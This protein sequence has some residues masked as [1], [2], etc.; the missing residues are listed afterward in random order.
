VTISREV[1]VISVGSFQ[2]CKQL[3]AVAFEFASHVHCIE[4]RAFYQCS[5][6]RFVSL[7]PSTQ[8]LRHYC[9]AKC[10][11]LRELRFEDGLSRL[12]IEAQVFRDCR[13]L[14]RIALPMS[15]RRDFGG[16][17]RGLRPAI[18]C[19]YDGKCVSDPFARSLVHVTHSNHSLLLNRSCRRFGCH[20]ILRV[21]DSQT[22]GNETRFVIWACRVDVVR[23]RPV[24]VRKYKL[25]WCVWF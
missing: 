4:A 17:L 10:R 25:Q 9:F 1:Q 8:L 12:R 11:N 18:I 7:P 24:H 14:A 19:W 3:R 5:H 15:S 6:L 2:S 16:D 20:L 22:P 13:L 21:Q 23:Q